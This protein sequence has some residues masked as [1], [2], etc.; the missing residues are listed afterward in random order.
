MFE[1]ISGTLVDATPHVAIVEANG[2][3]Y[4][5]SISL[6][7]FE[8]LPKM[9]SPL[10]LFTSFVV[11]EDSQK[12]YG[13]LHTQERDFFTTLCDISGIGPRLALA[14]LGHLNLGEL[15]IA[16]QHHDVTAITKVPGIGK[17]MA[18][19]LILELKGKFPH[20]EKQNIGLP[21]VQGSGV[22]ADAISALVNLGYNAADAQKAVNRALPSGEEPPLS[23]LISLALKVKK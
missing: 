11:R 23:Q 21:S 20:S 7:T 8:Q 2:L 19:R 1:Y 15:Q 14:I 13:F 4:A 6:S 12:L 3:G 16:T 5:L 22:V 18:E 9:G 17:K 10:K